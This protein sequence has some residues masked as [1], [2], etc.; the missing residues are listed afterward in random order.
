VKFLKIIIFV[1]SLLIIYACTETIGTNSKDII[2][3]EENVSFQFH[4]YPFL[5]LNCSY[6]GC[7][8]DES[9]AGGI[10]LT[11][12]GTLF[13]SPGMIIIGEPDKS[14]LIQIIENK[15]P[16]FTLFY[17]GNITENHKKGMR[18]WIIEG[19]KNN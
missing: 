5:K 4:V 7:H 1:F 13:S 12:Y 17:R 8:S 9:A 6:A 16:H 10:I 14:R 19:A 11:S 3:P 2:F 15:L 18:T